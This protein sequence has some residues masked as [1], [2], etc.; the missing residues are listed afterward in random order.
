VL[1]Y[2]QSPWGLI[3]RMNFV[4][5]NCLIHIRYEFILFKN[6]KK[7][8]HASVYV[9]Q[10]HVDLHKLKLWFSRLRQRLFLKLLRQW[11]HK[12]G[13]FL[14]CLQHSRPCCIGY[15]NSRLRLE[16]V[17][18]IQHGRSCCKHY[19]LMQLI[20]RTFSCLLHVLANTRVLFPLLATFWKTKSGWTEVESNS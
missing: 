14:S 2:D 9:I 17:Y 3:I 8:Q 16:F 7:S 5:L 19:I 20:S 18:P 1:P 10:I 4:Y 12:M 11:T 15:T 13:R 6:M